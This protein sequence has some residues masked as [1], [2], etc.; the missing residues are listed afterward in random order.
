MKT[1]KSLGCEHFL[2]DHPSGLN[3]KLNDEKYVKSILKAC[4]DYIHNV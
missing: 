4:K 2:M 3:R 1:L